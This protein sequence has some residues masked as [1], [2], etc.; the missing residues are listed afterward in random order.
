MTKQ[1]NEQ[2][3][4][5]RPDPPDDLKRPQIQIFIAAVEEL[6]QQR[7][8]TPCPFDQ[9]GFGD[10]PD[11]RVFGHQAIRPVQHSGRTRGKVLTLGLALLREQTRSLSEW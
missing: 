9:G 10:C 6:S 5:R 8:R 3:N 7:Q 4:G 1:F 2:R 11:L